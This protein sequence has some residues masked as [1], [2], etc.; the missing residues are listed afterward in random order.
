MLKLVGVSFQ[1][2]G[3]IFDF[4]AQDLIL[5]PGDQVI[6]ET[7]RGRALGT[8]LINHTRLHLKTHRLS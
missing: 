6:V 8:V 2:A 7:E 4:D 1:S 5:V 3:K